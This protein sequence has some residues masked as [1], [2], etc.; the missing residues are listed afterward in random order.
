MA[1]FN[2][3]DMGTDMY[4]LDLTNDDDEN[5]LTHNDH[6]SASNFTILLSPTLDLSSLLYLRSVAAEIALDQ[7]TVDALPLTAT[8]KEN[9]T[10]KVVVP[11]DIT[12]CNAWYNPIEM[13]SINEILFEIPCR[14]F[15]AEHP[16]EII[17]Y[18]NNLL[19]ESI[20]QFILYRYLCVFLDLD[21]FVSGGNLHAL[22]VTDLNLIR[23]YLDIAMFTRNTMHDT[24]VERL[25]ADHNIQPVPGRDSMALQKDGMTQVQ[26]TALIQASPSVF[27][28]V[29]DRRT[30]PLGERQHKTIDYDKFYGVY[31]GR[32]VPVEITQSVKTSTLNWLTNVQAL[33]RDEAGSLVINPAMKTEFE[34]YIAA[35][36]ALTQM[37]LKCREIITNLKTLIDKRKTKDRND[38]LFVT[39]F[40]SLMLDADTKLKCRFHLERERY[41]TTDGTS[42]TVNFPDQ[43][44]YVLGAACNHSLSVGPIDNK[45]PEVNQPR[46]T[47]NILSEDQ[48]LYHALRPLPQVIHIVTDLVF[49]KSRDM[50]LVNTPWKNFHLIYTFMLNQSNITRHY[51]S[52]INTHK[53]Y[54]RISD[55]NSILESFSFVMLDEKF[56]QIKFLPYCK[57]ALRLLIRPV[58][59][60]SR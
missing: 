26:E 23:R 12:S 15:Y 51:I 6:S 58:V 38:H 32:E 47:H 53:T 29:T 5:R 60:G 2:N 40:L 56:R 1:S 11:I 17:D 35:N 43:L 42:I 22:A 7:I 50:W 44:S 49:S 34:G 27:R 3:L 8:S 19:Q 54:Y 16:A 33:T 31:F 36:I 30:A 57:V 10:V 45:T 20:T 14:D 52:Q 46:L 9:I 21:I 13:S 59:Y 25:P 28:A 55:V 4:V 48:E 41:I 24:M 37:G 18:T 39:C